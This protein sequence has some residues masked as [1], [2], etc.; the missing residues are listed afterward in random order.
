MD[1]T[2]SKKGPKRLRNQEINNLYS[3]PKYYAYLTQE[4]K[5]DET[6]GARISYWSMLMMLICWA[7]V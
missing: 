1:L 5:K 7:I 2:S 4:S 3:P 6:S